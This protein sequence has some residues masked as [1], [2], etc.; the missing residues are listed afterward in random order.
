MD[1][2]LI[3]SVCYTPDTPFTYISTRSVFTPYERFKQLVKTIESIKNNVPDAYIV[4]VECSKF[5]TYELYIL[6]PMVNTFINLINNNE[7][8]EHVF[9]IYK[10]SGE[11]YM[12]LE[13][14]K[15][16]YHLDIKNQRFLFKISGR[17]QLS[18]EFEYKRYYNNRM[19]F[20][21]IN[22]DYNNVNTAMYKLC[23]S[24]IPNFI[25]Y[26][27]EPADKVVTKY[28][29]SYEQYITEFV[30]LNRHRVLFIEK[31]G[32]EG[33]VSVTGELWKN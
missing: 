9:N 3:T 21:A 17:Y 30:R 18:D 8:R 14:L 33:Y 15:Q 31:L 10:G 32:L 12:T 2:F 28:N 26:L 5:S 11:R 25:T 4:L 16:L 6:Q 1:I 13:A 7:A 24:D 20:L 22:G 27:E 23:W 19:N 29:G